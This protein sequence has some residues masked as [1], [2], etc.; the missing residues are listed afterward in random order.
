MKG[1]R[2]EKERCPAANGKTAQGDADLRHDGRRERARAL[3]RV[4][5]ADRRRRARRAPM[6]RP[7]PCSPP[8]RPDGPLGESRATRPGQPR[9]ARVSNSRDAAREFDVTA[10][11]LRVG[12]PSLRTGTRRLAAPSPSI[13]FFRAHAAGPTRQRATG[14]SEL[15][16]MRA[17]GGGR[18]PRTTRRALFDDDDAACASSRVPSDDASLR[19]TADGRCSLAVARR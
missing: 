3:A 7:I 2:A 9:A 17:L 6:A 4:D 18:R 14:A 12:G 13:G 11:G 16:D 1:A 5:A 10:C 19:G 15:S 8:R